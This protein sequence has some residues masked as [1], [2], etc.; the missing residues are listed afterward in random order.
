MSFPAGD[1]EPPVMPRLKKRSSIGTGRAS[2]FRAEVIVAGSVIVRSSGE[3]AK[4]NA[5]EAMAMNVSVVR[6]AHASYRPSPRPSR[7]ADR[8]KCVTKTFDDK[9]HAG[10][11]EREHVITHVATMRMARE[12]IAGETD[13][14]QLL[15][16]TD[17]LEAFARREALPR[18]DFDKCEDAAAAHDEIDLSAA[19][20]DVAAGNRIA[21]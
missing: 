21:A 7:I 19:Q 3:R 15:G 11:V 17:G 9:T 14:L 16:L 18:F 10:P 1:D 20:P 4:T 8:L 2:A 13:E 6:M 5:S 12:V